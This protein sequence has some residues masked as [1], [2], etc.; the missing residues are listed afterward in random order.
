[1]ELRKGRKSLHFF[2]FVDF[3]LPETAEEGLTAASKSAMSTG[4]IK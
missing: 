2:P 3:G 4:Q 1:M